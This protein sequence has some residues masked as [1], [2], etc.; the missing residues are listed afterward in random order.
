MLREFMY[1]GKKRKVFI[2]TENGTLIEGI[3]FS[4]ATDADQEGIKKFLEKYYIEKKALKESEVATPDQPVVP[5][6]ET[7]REITE[8]LKE[9]WKIYMKWFRR[10]NKVGISEVPIIVKTE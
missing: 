3:D 4:N 9:D 2:T 8:E 5:E 10:F 6:V 1:T 7:K